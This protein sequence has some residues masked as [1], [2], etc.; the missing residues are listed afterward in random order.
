MAVMADTRA[1]YARGG[2]LGQEGV[3]PV[4]WFSLAGG[5]AQG[6]LAARRSMLA[7]TVA[8]LR[9]VR[10]IV[11][12]ARRSSRGAVTTLLLIG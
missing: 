8:S 6:N 3:G 7:P 9:S 5:L 1:G 11:S 12:V 4:A 2:R 10:G